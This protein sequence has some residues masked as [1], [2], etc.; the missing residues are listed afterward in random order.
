MGGLK[1]QRLMEFVEIE[2][3]EENH[4][5]CLPYNTVDR[6]LRAIIV[7]LLSLT[8][9]G[10]VI[11]DCF[12]SNGAIIATCLRGKSS[13]QNN[14]IQLPTEE[15][16]IDTIIKIES[17]GFKYAYNQSSG[18]RG[19][20]QVTAACLDDWNEKRKPLEWYTIKD[21]F[22]PEVNKKIGTWYINVQIPKYFKAY[23]VADTLENR[24]IA[25]NWGIGN[26][27]RYYRGLITKLPLETQ[28]YIKK[29]K[30]RMKYVNN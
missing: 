19:V 3:V 29:Y 11:H 14:I 5:F 27:L 17:G 8:I 9:L 20:M 4:L 28:Q 24:L 21:L 26:F 25:Y 18:A 22:N 10:L 6:M 16:N 30:E 23:K 12:G 7:L 1:M 13:S 2:E 15:V